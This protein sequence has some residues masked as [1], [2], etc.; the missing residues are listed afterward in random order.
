MTHYS[1]RDIDTDS[2]VFIA[3]ILLHEAEL[4]GRREVISL[5]TYCQTENKNSLRFLC[6]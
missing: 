3:F 2:K 5:M 6:F 4:K 1:H